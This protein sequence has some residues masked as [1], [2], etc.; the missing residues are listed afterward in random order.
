M[1]RKP[2]AKKQTQKE[3]L[4]ARANAFRAFA[5]IF[6]DR[7]INIEGLILQEHDYETYKG[8]SEICDGLAIICDN[9]AIKEK[10]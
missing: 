7:A 8:L 2:R 1:I 10:L 4:G 9:L 5:K 6:N 3:S